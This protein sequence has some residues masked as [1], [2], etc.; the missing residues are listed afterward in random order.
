MSQISDIA[1]PPPPIHKINPKD[2]GN[3][4]DA[5][6]KLKDD[7]WAKWWELFMHAIDL[8]PGRLSLLLGTLKRPD[9]TQ[10]P[11]K[12]EIWEANVEQDAW[13]TTK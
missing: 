3:I 7:N 4:L 6:E 13:S 9:S 5:R 8:F 2:Y 11:A 12:A 1:N 10:Y